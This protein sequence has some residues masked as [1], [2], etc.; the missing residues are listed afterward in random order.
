MILQTLFTRFI[1]TY[2]KRNRAYPHAHIYR[3][4]YIFFVNLC[5][6]SLANDLHERS[7]KIAIKY[8]IND[9]I[10]WT[11]TVTNPEK[12][13]KESIRNWATISAYCV[14]T[15]CKKEWEPAEYKHP[16]H[17]CK[18]KCKALF[19]HLCQFCL[20]QWHL[21][22]SLVLRELCVAV[23]S[24]WRAATL[25]CER[26]RTLHFPSLGEVAFLGF[27]IGGTGLFQVYIV[28]LSFLW[29]AT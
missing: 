1:S 25:F 4:R 29:V 11:V 18:D 5:V 20:W 21:S 12:Q 2:T 13:I 8:C 19:T 6:W 14:Q 15:V 22:R 16:H 23:R 24:R 27:S 3:E 9:R 26:V 17:H 10:H 28:Q 7:P